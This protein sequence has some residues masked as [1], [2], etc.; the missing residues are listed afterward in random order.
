MRRHA[1]AP[2]VALI[3][4]GG[5]ALAQQSLYDGFWGHADIPECLDDSGRFSTCTAL[6]IA[7][8]TLSGEESDCAM[9]FHA[10][11]PAFETAL[12]YDLTCQ[13]EGESW[14]SRVLFFLDVDGRLTLLDS[15]GPRVYLPDLA[16]HGTARGTGTVPSK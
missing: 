6:V 12:V 14:T 16:A 8:G 5:P 7:N 9:A 15:F 4:T 10:D 1:L 13:G 3:L 11:V 2:L